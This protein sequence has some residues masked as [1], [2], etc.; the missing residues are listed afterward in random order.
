MDQP[1]ILD[2]PEAE[3][4]SAPEKGQENTSGNTAE[5]IAAAM[6]QTS[7]SAFSLGAIR[8]KKELESQQ[9]LKVS[10]SRTGANEAFTENDMLIH[11]NKYA[12]RMGSR[13]QKI[14]ESLM[15]MQAPVLEGTVV[16]HELPNESSKIDF[17]G[18][19]HDLVGYLRG[20]LHN[21]EL[22][23][24][25]VVN[26][27]IDNRLAFTPQDRYNRLNQINPALETLRRT[28]DLDF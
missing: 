24:R 26:E 21:H 16:V 28:F 27:T 15:L 12:S 22:N 10:E 4:I 3:Q 8:A 7:V 18:G 23:I 19:L 5:A 6:P 20:K 9:H 14:M 11:W 17:D 2:V 25:L 1:E 13:G